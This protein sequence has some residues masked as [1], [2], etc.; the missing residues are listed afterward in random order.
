MIWTLDSARHTDHR[1][2]VHLTPRACN[3]LQRVTK[4]YIS[5][6]FNTQTGHTAAQQSELA[7]Q[8]TELAKRSTKGKIPTMYAQHQFPGHLYPTMNPIESLPA[9]VKGVL[10]EHTEDLDMR[11]AMD[12]CMRGVCSLLGR[13]MFET[14]DRA[15]IAQEAD[16]SVGEAKLL[17][18][19]VWTCETPPRVASPA[20]AAYVH[21]VD[22][23]RAW[24]VHHPDMVELRQHTVA[25]STNSGNLVGSFASFLYAF[26]MGKILHQVRVALENAGVQV[27]LLCK[28]GLRVTKFLS[29]DTL[30]SIARTASEAVLPGINAVWVVKPHDAEIK[31]NKRGTGVMFHVDLA[32]FE[33]QLQEGPDVDSL[34]MHQLIDLKNTFHTWGV[35]WKRCEARPSGTPLD[36][37]PLQES[38]AQG[39]LMYAAD[40]ITEL[41]AREGDWVASRI[42]PGGVELDNS[43]VRDALARG[44]LKFTREQLDAMDVPAGN[45]FV[46][47]DD[48]WYSRCSLES[49]HFV[50]ADDAYFVPQVSL[51]SYDYC[52]RVFERR[53]IKCDDVFVD[54]IELQRSGNNVM[55]PIEKIGRKYCDLKCESSAESFIKRYE[56][57]ETKK[58]A[59]QLCFVPPTAAVD[60]TGKYNMFHSFRGYSYD[61]PPREDAVDHLT[62]LLTHIKEVIAAS[63]VHQFKFV[64]LWLAQMIQYPHLKS[65]WPVF[66]GTGGAGKSTLMKLIREMIGVSMFLTTSS[67]EED[68]WGKFNSGIATK[69]FIEFAE[70][71]KANF[72]Q[73]QGRVKQILEDDQITVQQKHV[74]SK[75]IDSFHHGCICTNNMMPVFEDRRWAPIHVSEHLLIPKNCPACVTGTCDGCARKIAYHT[76][77]NTTVVQPGA[78]R[79]FLELLTNLEC[80]RKL[81]AQHV[82]QSEQADLIRE[83]SKDVIDHALAHLVKTRIEADPACTTELYTPEDLFDHYRHYYKMF[84]KGDE[85]GLAAFRNRLNSKQ[86]AGLKK[87]RA[88]SYRGKTFANAIWFKQIDFAQLAQT[89]SVEVRTPCTGQGTASIEQSM[90]DNPPAR[91]VET[92]WQTAFDDTRKWIDGFLDTVYEDEQHS[93]KKQRN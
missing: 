83:G 48:V 32:G 57:D 77:T 63:D 73:A 72:F 38:L 43:Q 54:K 16:I 74:D 82:P 92:Y 11:Q 76:R 87:V 33:P 85:L 52:K 13:P 61:F 79:I 20:Y 42:R 56:K 24:L 62:V 66:V 55:V 18:N 49:H 39:V 36:I 65:V 9:C 91:A 3:W 89:L 19:L 27:Q 69:Y 58:S 44:Q 45:W 25:S 35:T 26:V 7:L 2:D 41:V 46:Q 59:D 40:E 60:T 50:E 53:F 64:M 1:I 8:C 51:Y 67:P 75:M 5:K 88:R 81:T 34:E 15:L 29:H 28:D 10:L 12:T 22:A 90:R 37:P 17:T 4:P 80:P 30:A 21:E 86:L 31:H 6:H 71:N 93:D 78:V 84:E 47:A 68:V 70:V 23:R 14:C